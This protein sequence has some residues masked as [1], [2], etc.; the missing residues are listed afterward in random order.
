MG[1]FVARAEL[2]NAAMYASTV[3]AAVKIF[4]IKEWCV[5]SAN[6]R[7]H[8][9]FGMRLITLFA[10]LITGAMV[11]S[12]MLQPIVKAEPPPIT[13][14]LNFHSD[15]RQYH[16]D[17]EVGVTI[18]VK[19]TSSNDI[20]IG[21]GFKSQRFFLNMRII[22]PAGNLLIPKVDIPAISRSPY[23]PPLG[24]VENSEG[25]LVMTAPCEIFKANKK[26]PSE[27]IN[28]NTYYNFEYSGYYSAQVQLSLMEF[29][30]NG[31]C[32]PNDYKWLG[33]LKSKTQY[34]HVSGKLPIHITPNRWHMSWKN[35][36]LGKVT[37]QIHIPLHDGW[38]QH[39]NIDSNSIRVN[40]GE[41]KC[42]KLVNKNIL[43][44]F[45][46]GKD[47]IDSLQDTCEGKSYRVWVSG[48][49]S[50]GS[51]FCGSQKILIIP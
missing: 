43:K 44:C 6:K 14:N 36:I 16:C 18:E 30:R 47:C 24:F 38:K 34:F 10:F 12:P 37:V 40:K 25:K 21:K 48:L 2:K 51:R 3:P 35:G 27:T 33:V 39:V 4:G 23:T 5:I 50:N 17:D 26:L 29:K 31:L 22:D 9:E 49:F 32:N 7:S 11:M 13:V 15:S 8:K 28:L 42:E 19:N 46:N 45:C 41:V 1:P 20:L